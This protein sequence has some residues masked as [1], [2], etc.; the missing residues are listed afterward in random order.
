MYPF[1]P[2]FLTQVKK[3]ALSRMFHLFSKAGYSKGINFA[4]DNSDN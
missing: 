4:P 1:N 2:F 3:T